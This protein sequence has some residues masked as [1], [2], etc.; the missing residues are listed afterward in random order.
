VFCLSM[1]IVNHTWNTATVLRPLLHMTRG[2]T[3]RELDRLESQTSIPDVCIHL[4]AYIT[5]NN[6]T[7]F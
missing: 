1:T 7:S 5:N 3:S 2:N 4:A 6:V